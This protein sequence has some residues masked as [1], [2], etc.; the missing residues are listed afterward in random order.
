MT[1]GIEAYK[2]TLFLP[3]GGNEPQE[4]FHMRLRMWGIE[5]SCI[6]EHIMQPFDLPGERFHACLMASSHS[7]SS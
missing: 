6:L 7:V 2:H 3:L 5:N 1:I 4:K